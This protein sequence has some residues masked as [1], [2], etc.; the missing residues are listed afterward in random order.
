[1]QL[2]FLLFE[3]ERHAALYTVAAEYRPLVQYLVN[4]HYARS[5]VYQHVEVAVEIIL[6]RGKSEQ[7]VHYCV[8]VLTLFQVECKAKS[9]QVR[10]IADVGY[11]PDLSVLDE[12]HHLVDYRFDS[13]GRG[14]LRYLDAT[15]VRVVVVH[16]ADFH[17]TRTG[18]IDLVHLGF[19]VNDVASPGEIRAFKRGKRV[20]L[21]VFHQ[22]DGSLAYLAEVERA[23]VACHGNCQTE[24]T[25]NQHCRVSHREKARLQHGVVVI[26]H[27]VHGVLVYLC[28]KFAAYRLQLCFGVSRSRVR[29]IAGIR[30]AEVALAVNIGVQERFVSARKAHHCLIYRS[31]AVGVQPHGLTYDIRGFR[32]VSRQ[33]S[34]FIHGIEQLAV[35]RLEAVYLRQRAADDNA[36]RIGHVVFF[37]GAYDVLLLDY[38]AALD[39]SPSYRGT[40]PPGLLLWSV[41]LQIY[42]PLSWN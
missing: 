13:G 2:L 34:H 4:A 5:S 16:R 14:Y 15:R 1:M 40:E 27:H 33:K 12:F 7:L 17:R 8:G 18:A 29:H 10:F 41:F 38:S 25:V 20:V 22:C 31:V 6:Q 3:V 37:Q 39:V 28:E 35:R 9:R 19:V 11:L 23:D 24:I 36:H 42:L 32:T 26:G 30:L 21:R